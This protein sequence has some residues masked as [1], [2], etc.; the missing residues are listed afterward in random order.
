MVDKHV[1]KSLNMNLP[2]L[3]WFMYVY[4]FIHARDYISRSQL[5]CSWETINFGCYHLSGRGS[6][7]P[8]EQCL[9]TF[10][11]LRTDKMVIKL[12]ADR[13][14]ITFFYVDRWQYYIK[15]NKIHL[16]IVKKL[17]LYINKCFFF[18]FNVFADRF[19]LLCKLFWSVAIVMCI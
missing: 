2:L 13:H 12:T 18:N 4:L 19:D 14:S 10:C 5:D 1:L 7:L 11:Q 9:S 3:M 16:L 15:N 6:K 17:Q 8:L